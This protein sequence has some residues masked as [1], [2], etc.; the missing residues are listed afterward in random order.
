MTSD[1]VSAGRAPRVKAS[2][3]DEQKTF[4]RG[5]LIEAAIAVFE[6]KGFSGA[7]VDDI[8][9]EAGASRATFYA[10][11]KN[12]DDV[13]NELFAQMVPQSEEAF[14]QLDSAI[15]SGSRAEVRAWVLGAFG[16]WKANGGA[17]LALEQIV[18]SGGF[19][20]GGLDYV[21]AEAMPGFLRAW[22]PKRRDE[23]RLRIY[24]LG[25][26]ITRTYRA[27]E[28]DGLFADLDE[29]D[30]IEVITDLWITGLHL[31][32]LRPDGDWARA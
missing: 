14:A 7:T 13:A 17:V 3:R 5:R 15:A 32:R 31:Q 1:H 26:L 22:G 4:T 18:A 12:K 2:L 28:L 6:S 30:I 19:G 9:T 24:L 21:Q 10:H 20:H 29:A 25:T 8:V 16:W 27:W 11:F 23:A